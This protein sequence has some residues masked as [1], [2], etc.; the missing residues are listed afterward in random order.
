MFQFEKKKEILS[1]IKIIIVSAC[2]FI[3]DYQ[4]VF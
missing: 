1:L 4:N 2:V 3:Q